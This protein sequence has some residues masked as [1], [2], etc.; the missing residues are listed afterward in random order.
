LQKEQ[1]AV[2]AGYRDGLAGCGKM[3]KCAVVATVESG[4]S[5]VC[6]PNQPMW[7]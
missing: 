6:V 3:Q 5:N 2:R 4:G 7:P 1:E